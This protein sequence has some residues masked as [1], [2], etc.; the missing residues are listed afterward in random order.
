MTTAKCII[1]DKRPINGNGKYC[2]PCFN[3]IEADKKSRKAREPERFIVYRDI[4]CGL[5]KGSDGNYTP[6]LLRR[7]V[8]Y[9][10]KTRT[11]DLNTY[12]KGYTRQQIKR[13]KATCLKLA[14][15]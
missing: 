1:C 8:K 2:G 11:I 9:L 15:A 4:V 5:Y 14:N 6:A 3:K 7:S 13:M 10:P 12:I